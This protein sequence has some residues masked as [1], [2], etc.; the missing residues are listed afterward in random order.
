MSKLTWTILISVAL[1]IIVIVMYENK[2]SK[3]KE[4]V[5]AAVTDGGTTTGTGTD[6]SPTADPDAGTNPAGRL[7]TNM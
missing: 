4:A 1:M 5:T 2:L 7:N 6:S 3:A